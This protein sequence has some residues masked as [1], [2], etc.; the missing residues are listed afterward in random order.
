[1]GPG[2]PERLII[3]LIGAETPALDEFLGGRVHTSGLGARA[4]LELEMGLSDDVGI[5]GDL[6][7]KARSG[8]R[9]DIRLDGRRRGGVDVH[10]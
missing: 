8:R 1:M 9:G 2:R 6:G 5:G 7:A 3:L 4:F 10:P